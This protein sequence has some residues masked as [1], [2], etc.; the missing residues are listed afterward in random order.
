MKEEN[1]THFIQQTII[2]PIH[3]IYLYLNKDLIGVTDLPGG[4]PDVSLQDS[5]R[6][7]ELTSGGDT[8]GLEISIQGQVVPES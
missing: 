1:Q 5:L 2:K 7:T 4:N 3:I 6:V 8:R